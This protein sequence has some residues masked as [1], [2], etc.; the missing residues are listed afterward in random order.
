MLWNTKAKEF[1]DFQEKER[2]NQI[3]E[4]KQKNLRNMAMCPKK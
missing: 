4:I 1:P 2:K 3:V